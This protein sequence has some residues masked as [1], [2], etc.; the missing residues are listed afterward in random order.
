MKLTTP[1]DWIAADRDNVWH[2]YSAI[3]ADLP[4][5]PVQSA[6]G[7]R[8]RLADGRQLI[9]GMSS[10]WCAIHGYN[11]PI[12]NRAVEK[13]LADMAHVMFGGLTHGPAVR[14]AQQLV[15]LTPDPLQTVFFADSGSVAVEGM[16][17]PAAHPESYPCACGPPARPS[18]PRGR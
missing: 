7:V 10:W 1:E 13:Q 2:P 4:V 6:Q 16:Y 14:L 3:G 11:H 8:L 17:V 12:L 15:A 18:D 5:Y 9:D